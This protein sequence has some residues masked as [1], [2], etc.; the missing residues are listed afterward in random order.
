MID[1]SITSGVTDTGA[2]CALGNE[3]QRWYRFTPV[4]QIG[5]VPVELDETPCNQL[6]RVHRTRGVKVSTFQSQGLALYGGVDLKTYFLLCATLGLTQ[7]RAL[8]THDSL[9]EEDFRHNDPHY[10]LFV[11]QLRMQDYALCLEAPRVCRGCK[12]F[13]RALG[14]EQEIHALRQVIQHVRLSKKDAMLVEYETPML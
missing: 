7:Y 13:Y 2:V 10:C 1:V 14:L 11:E 4:A 6:F 3:L 12:S 8:Q 5:N 9:Y